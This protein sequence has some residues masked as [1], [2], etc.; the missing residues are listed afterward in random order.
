MAPRF[1]LWGWTGT[2]GRGRV[3]SS[4]GCRGGHAP[5]KVPGVTC[6]LGS[7]LIGFNYGRGAD[8]SKP[9]YAGDGFLMRQGYTL[10][11]SGW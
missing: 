5:G 6:S 3:R 1:E 9:E 11:W 10:M 8:M 7:G 2:A 4:Q